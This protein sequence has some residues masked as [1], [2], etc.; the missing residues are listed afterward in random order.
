MNLR[1]CPKEFNKIER[2]WW[3]FYLPTVEA[4]GMMSVGKYSTLK[5]LCCVEGQIEYNMAVLRKSNYG[6]TYQEAH[7]HDASGVDHKK[8]T[9]SPVVRQ[10]D[11]KMKLKNSLKKTLGLFEVP[12]ENEERNEMEGLLDGKNVR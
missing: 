12:A 8:I 6:A 7:Y 9:V 3:K 2:K 1:R 4:R 5:D 10:L 11:D